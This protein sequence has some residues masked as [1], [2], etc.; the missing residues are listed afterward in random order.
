MLAKARSLSHGQK[1]F[2]GHAGAEWREDGQ[3]DEVRRFLI[4]FVNTSDNCV[5]RIILNHSRTE[6]LR[7][8]LYNKIYC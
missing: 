8:R 2:P 7:Q 3:F 5:T 1:P 6:T 4:G